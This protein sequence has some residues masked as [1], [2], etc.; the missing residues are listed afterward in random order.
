M[1]SSAAESP[2]SSTLVSVYRSP[3][4]WMCA[5]RERERIVF[6]AFGGTLG[7]PEKSSSFQS[8][9]LD[10][11]TALQRRQTRGRRQSSARGTQANISD[12]SSGASRPKTVAASPG[13]DDASAQ[14]EDYLDTHILD[15][16]WRQFPQTERWWLLYQST[17]LQRA[18]ERFFSYVQLECD[19]VRVLVLLS[20]LEKIKSK[21]QTRDASGQ[22]WCRR[23]DDGQDQ[24]A[25]PTVDSDSHKFRNSANFCHC[26][27]GQLQIQL[28]LME[29]E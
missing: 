21:R 19:V 16:R 22:Q 7:R 15:I 1:S 9:G 2:S 13:L 25:V 27:S 8:D 18:T 24:R 6:R 28:M 14:L 10:V 17:I 20:R 11:A 26:V 5:A 12:R 29:L 3:S 4:I 23:M